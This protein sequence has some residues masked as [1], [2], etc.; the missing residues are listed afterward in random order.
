MY[1]SVTRYSGY[2]ANFVHDPRPPDR[3]RERSGTL[4]AL[5]LPRSQVLHELS[6]D[7]TNTGQ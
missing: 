4:F 7:E 5:V 2:C 1:E 3:E 6:H